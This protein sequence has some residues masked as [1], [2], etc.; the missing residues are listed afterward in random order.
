MSSART[1]SNQPTCSQRVLRNMIPSHV[2]ALCCRL[3]SVKGALD[4]WSDLKV[5]HQWSHTP[6]IMPGPGTVPSD[7]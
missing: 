4:N 3:W 7:C 1:A 2:H 5:T 6:A